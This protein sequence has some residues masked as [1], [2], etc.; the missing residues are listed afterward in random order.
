M[1]RT[2]RWLLL[3]LL[4]LPLAADDE[5]RFQ[6]QYGRNFSY[7]GGRVKIDHGFGPLVIRTHSGADVQVR[8]TIRA[9]DEEFGKEI[10]I[11]A[12]TEGSGVSVRTIYPNANRSG[13]LSYS[14]DMTVTVPASAAIEAS[15]RFGSVDARGLGAASVITNRQGS[16]T[17][18]DARGSQNLTNAFGSITVRNVAGDL[19]ASN[20]N[21]SVNVAKVSGALNV[22]NKFGSVN[23]SDADRGV[24]IRNANGS[25]QV[26]DVR[27]ALRATNAFGS[28]N[29]S[30][31]GG[32]A[33]I[34]TS[35]ASAQVN[36][37][38]GAATIS[39]QFGSV[40]VHDVG[41]NLTLEGANSQ[42]EAHDIDGNVQVENSFGPV[43]VD[44]VTG[45]VAITNA[46]GS[47]AVR[48]LRGGRCQPVTLTTN[49]SS[50]KVA[51]P[52]SASYAVR[53]RTSFGRIASEL[54]ITTNGVTENVLDGTIGRGG[55][56]MK[57]TN[58]N[59][60][61]TIEKD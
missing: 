20:S 61:I 18:L 24:D 43:F 11:V 47:I 19:E 31:I 30:T 15:N 1:S 32:T 23:V 52:G 22:R 41:G 44:G 50:L 2:G 35:H 36:G 33:E 42:L 16:I 28:V 38:G 14:V 17:L 5:S 21:G 6:V 53:A 49:F 13:R 48:G 3:A 34:T 27:G 8:A 60:S 45:A 12:H 39:N 51:V 10:R 26:S 55:C 29:A 37:I 7:G 9:S 59:G 57:L 56:E 54:P 40:A 58:A 4:A 25:I 46:N